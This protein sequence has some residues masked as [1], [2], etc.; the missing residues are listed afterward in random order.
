MQPKFKF[1]DRVSFTKDS[2]YFGHVGTVQAVEP[3]F[4]LDPKYPVVYK[5]TIKIEVEWLPKYCEVLFRDVFIVQE[6]ETNLCVQ[7]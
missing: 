2:F 6:L 1:L 7:L 4:L 5:Y 3:L